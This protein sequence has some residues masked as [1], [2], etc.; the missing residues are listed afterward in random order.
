MKKENIL[1]IFILII[2]LIFI[3]YSYFS[4]GLI[5]FLINSDTSY[6]VNFVNSFGIFS[7]IVFVFLVILEVVFAPIPPFALYIVAGVIF[8]GFFGGI[9]VLIGNICGSIIDFEIARIFGKN[10][11]EKKLNKKKKI[12]FDEFIKKYGAWS[13]FLLRINPL[14]SSDLFSYLAGLSK[15]KLKTFILATSCGLIPLIFFQTYLGD[16]FIK[17]NSLLF[18]LFLFI[19]FLY[20]ILFLYL[21]LRKDKK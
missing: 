1:F 18:F 21:F 12:Q 3:P 2:L 7:L 5:Y 11:I 14:T 9:L 4:K 6:I 19:S 13:I 17:N 16:F 15:M 20:F 8:G 10:Y